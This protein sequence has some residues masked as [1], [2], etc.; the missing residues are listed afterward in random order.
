M[1]QKP[2]GNEKLHMN[3]YLINGHEIF[4]IIKWTCSVSR[5]R[6]VRQFVSRQDFVRKVEEQVDRVQE[7][8]GWQDKDWNVEVKVEEN[9]D[10]SRFYSV[11]RPR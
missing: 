3:G 7:R 11:A 2:F 8:Q 4:K 6:F 5:R 10:V 9:E 1:N